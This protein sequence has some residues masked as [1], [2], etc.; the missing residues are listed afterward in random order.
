M[1]RELT[2]YTP[3][4]VTMALMAL[5]AN[6]GNVAKTAD[7]LIGDEFQV[8]ADRLRAWKNDTHAQ[9]YRD[10]EE[11]YG[12]ELENEAIQHARTVLG[13]AAEIELELLEKVRTPS[14]ELA[15]QALRA[16]ADVKS[17][18]VNAVLALTGR[19]PTGQKDTGADVVK[20]FQGMVDKGWLKLSPGVDLEPPKQG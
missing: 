8:P 11:R 12:N 9:R 2:R 13:K 5:V 14:P 10:L 7:Q 15:P 4:Q 18:N 1:G 16:V 19:T 17:K 3:E 20:L 6:G